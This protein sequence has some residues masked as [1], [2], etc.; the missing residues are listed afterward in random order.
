[1][2]REKGLGCSAALA[3]WVEFFNCTRCR[4]VVCPISNVKKISLHKLRAQL[5]S[6]HLTMEKDMSSD[7]SRSSEGRARGAGADP[8]AAWLTRTPPVLALPMPLLVPALRATSTTGTA[9]AGD[10][11]GFARRQGKAVSISPGWS[12]T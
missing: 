9:A 7:C 10:D 6:T 3:A 1:M 2:L 8:E 12:S 11:F 5:M 4:V